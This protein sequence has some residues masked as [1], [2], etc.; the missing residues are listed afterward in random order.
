MRNVINSYWFTQ[1]G[2]PR[3][4]GIV[5]IVD[6]FD[7]DLFYIGNAD[8]IDEMDDEQYIV[9]TGAKFPKDAGLRI[10]DIK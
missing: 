5:H 4:I 9:D 2:N 10:F 6:E 1:L 7:G 3:T 8:G